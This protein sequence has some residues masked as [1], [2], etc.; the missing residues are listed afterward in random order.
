MTTTRTSSRSST[1][2]RIKGT[3]TYTV[4][5]F[6]S[7][8]FARNPAY[9]NGALTSTISRTIEDKHNDVDGSDDVESLNDPPM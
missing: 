8:D 3:C 6:D 2:K 4:Q 1:I 5:V 7:T 9:R